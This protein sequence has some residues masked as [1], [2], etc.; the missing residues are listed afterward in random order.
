VLSRKAHF[1]SPSNAP[2]FKSLARPKVIQ[3]DFDYL[4]AK[5]DVQKLASLIEHFNC[6]WIMVGSQR[7]VHD[8][9]NILCSSKA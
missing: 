4:I 1:R 6:R 8:I 7:M 9:A 2:N 3:I 5:G